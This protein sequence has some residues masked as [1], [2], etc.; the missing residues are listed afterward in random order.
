MKKTVL[1]LAVLSAFSG[2]AFAQ[3]NVQ[4][5][6]RMTGGVSYVDKIATLSTTSPTATG[7]RWGLDSGQYTQSRI[8]FRGTEDLGGGLKTNFTL[9]SGL[10]IDNGA[11]A[12]GLA[13]SRKTTVGLAGAFGE[14]EIGRRKDYIDEV[15]QDFS[16]ETRLLPFTGRV[17]ANNM[18]RS[19]GGRANNMIYYTTPDMGGFTGN[20]SYAF[21]ETAGSITTGQ[22]FG[23]GGTYANGPFA[24]GFGYWQS[25]LGVVSAGGVTTSSDNEATTGAG[26]KTVGLGNA[27]DTC[28][29]TWMIGSSYKLGNATLRGTYSRVEQPLISAAG[30]VAPNFATA[31]TGTIGT[32]AF[33]IG[34]SNNDKANI[35]DLGVDYDMGSWTFKGSVIQSR[36]SFVGARDDGRL[37]M[38]GAGADYKFS[39][40]TL[41]Y[42]MAGTLRTSHMYSP[43]LTNVGVPGA[44][45]SQ[46]ALLAGIYHTF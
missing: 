30:P 18:D 8:G 10:T 15:S 27:G 35:V 19:T 46:S 26:C 45:N 4:I 20:L 25:K 24:I 34:G 12:S 38:F 9:E 33:T 2:T 22:A 14:V 44:D 42:V 5:Y 39:K 21:G 7:S 36:Y 13:Y 29:K 1:A 43:G 6:G 41:L 28:L 37:T 3:T 23:F 40:R 11:A 31:F 16:T 17:H 32:S